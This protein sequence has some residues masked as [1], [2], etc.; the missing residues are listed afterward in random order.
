MKT[1][2]GVNALDSIIKDIKRRADMPADNIHFH[3]AY[4]LIYVES[5]S[6][7]VKINNCEYTVKEHSMIVI[8][9][10]EEHS[11]HVLTTP[12]Q[13]CFVILDTEQTDR[14][15]SSPELMS[16]FKN[17]SADFCHIFEMEKEHKNV[18]HIFNE[19]LNSFQQ[20]MDFKG[21]YQ[22]ALITQ[23]LV[24]MYNLSGKSQL[25]LK[26]TRKEIFAVQKYIEKNFTKNLLVS[27]IASHFYLD[28]CYLTHSFK[29]VTGYSPK[30]YILLNRLSYAKQLLL[31]TDLSVLQ[32][33]EQSGFSD[34]NNFIRYFKREFSVTPKRYRAS[35]NV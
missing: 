23:L 5:G 14:M 35:N 8:S 2:G 31:Q 32:V 12:Y 21:E 6:A 15:V 19:L 26:N 28:H 13:R 24:M 11:T 1:S 29:Q 4:E 10:L 17:R 27:E 3:H 34:V 9:N 18:L 22:A 20:D 25:N 16:I 33:S 7:S 30:E